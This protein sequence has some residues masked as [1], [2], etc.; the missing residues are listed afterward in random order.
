LKI[1]SFFALAMALVSFFLVCLVKRRH[2]HKRF[3]LSWSC[4]SFFIG[5]MAAPFCLY[6]HNLRPECIDLRAYSNEKSLLSTGYYTL[7]LS[8]LHQTFSKTSAT[9]YNS[10]VQIPAP[11]Q[12][13]LMLKHFYHLYNNQ[14]NFSVYRFHCCFIGVVVFSFLILWLRWFRFSQTVA[15]VYRFVEQASGILGLR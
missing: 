14:W 5:S 8:V 1:P 10:T 11:Q 3:F 12:Q 2:R 6:V 9:Y 7:V 13:S 15:D 4:Y